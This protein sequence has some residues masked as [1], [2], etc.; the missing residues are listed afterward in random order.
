MDFDF[1]F[2]QGVGLFMCVGA[3]IL[4][5]V[6]AMAIRAF[7]SGRKNDQENRGVLNQRGN[8]RPTYD[9]RRVESSGG[10]GSEGSNIPQTGTNQA[11]VYDDKRGISDR[12][13]GDPLPR[14]DRDDEPRS[15]DRDR[16]RRDDDDVRSSGG[17]GN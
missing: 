3:I 6:V 15:R 10:F 1:G 2:L 5:I 16:D 12:Q 11:R 17:F 9:S 4:V 8:E 14:L 13:A 7:T